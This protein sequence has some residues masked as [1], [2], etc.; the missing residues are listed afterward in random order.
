M[1]GTVLSAGGRVTLG[2]WFVFIVSLLV[3]LVMLV[4]G[5][6]LLVRGG[7]Q[8]AL[9]LRVPALV[10]GLTIVAFG[11]SAPELAV[12]VSAALEGSTELALANI[13]GSNVANIL[14]VLGLAALVQPLAVERRLLVREVP[15]VVVLQLLVPIFCWDG[16]IERWEG[17]VLLFGGVFYNGWI[18]VAS[19]RRRDLIGSVEGDEEAALDPAAAELMEEVGEAKGHPAVHVLS[20]LGGLIVL[21]IGA[22]L[23]VGGATIAAEWLG[24]SERF[25]GLTVVALGT[26]APELATSVVSAYRGDVDL[27]LGN[28]IGSNILNIGLVLGLTSIIMP[29]AVADPGTWTDFA[30]AVGTTML[31]API[32]LV[33]GVNRVGGAVMVIAYVSYLL[34]TP[35]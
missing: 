26:S 22:N 33:N 19:L 11:T 16:A 28:A 35:S 32:V 4:V 9:A 24:F 23:F 18:L 30:V 27:A 17:A 12:S 5:A 8:L 29:I 2:C 31:L 34:L 15:V 14:F 10:V 21:V 7:G 1:R 6:E 25:I 3:G 13:T 20:L